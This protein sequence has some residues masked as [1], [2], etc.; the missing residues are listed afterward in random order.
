MQNP[1]I[2]YD[3]EGLTVAYVDG[4]LNVCVLI[5]QFTKQTDKQTKAYNKKW[6]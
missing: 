6:K 5:P 2:C 1:C 4:H 3:P